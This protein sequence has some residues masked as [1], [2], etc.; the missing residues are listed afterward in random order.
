[1]TS[2][3]LPQRIAVVG[4]SCRAAVACLQRS[5]AAALAADQFADA[6]LRQMAPAMQLAD[7][8]AEI[9][10][11]LAA[12]DATHWMYVG[13]LENHPEIIEAAADVR[14][15]LG[16]PAPALAAIRDPLT[17][18]Q[19]LRLAGFPF[20]ETQLEPPRAGHWIVKPRKTA[21]GL[22]IGP[23]RQ[24]VE[25]EEVVYQRLLR[26]QAYGAAF[27]AIDGRAHFLGA[28]RQLFGR[29]WKAPQPYQY[30]GSVG[31]ISLAD[32]HQATLER[33]AN[34]LVASTALSGLFGVDFILSDGELWPLEI[35]PRFTAAM[36]L[37][38]VDV[39]RLHLSAW[40][41]EWRGEN[42][43]PIDHPVDVRGKLFVYAPVDFVWTEQ[44]AAAICATGATIA[45][46]PMVGA[47]LIQSSPVLTLLDSAV[48]PGHLARQLARQAG[49]IR[50]LLCHKRP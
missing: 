23:F 26:G 34:Y 10:A 12:T 22:S 5:G 29:K 15:L 44:L 8:P 3:N 4:C 46:V 38:P 25:T 32:T 1:M 2:P 40:L 20:P 7:Y 49:Q 14:P 48:S 35:N 30:A 19:T 11:W 36:E 39:M 9:P 16:V 13:G 31:P 43:T 17:L 27:V 21:G 45:D 42:A 37:L 6:D 24:P 47:V 41:P 50:H 33:L 18:Q 28:T